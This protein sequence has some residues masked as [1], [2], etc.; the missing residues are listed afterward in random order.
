[1]SNMISACYADSLLSVVPGE[2]IQ[3]ADNALTRQMASCVVAKCRKLGLPPIPESIPKVLFTESEKE[4]RELQSD[5]QA[6]QDVND[7][8]SRAGAAEQLVK[9]LRADK[10]ALENQLLELQEANENLLKENT[11]L[12]LIPALSDSKTQSVVE[13]STETT[14]M[15]A[16]IRKMFDATVVRC[17]T[18]RRQDFAERHL[19]TEKVSSMI[20]SLMRH[21]GFLESIK[22]HPGLSSLLEQ[23]IMDCAT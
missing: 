3:E 18:E 17:Q 4:L 14:V 9:Q 15:L 23:A 20:G 19:L 16:E 5:T 21:Q 2:D 11:E 7:A 22:Q 10:L 13:P 1:M 12:K 8:V 6:L